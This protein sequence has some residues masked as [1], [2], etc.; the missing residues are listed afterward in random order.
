[1]DDTVWIAKSHSPLIMPMAPV[2]S[3]NKCIVIVRNP[4]DSMVSFLHMAS[5]YNHSQKL[6]FDFETSYP[7]DWDWYV[8]YSCGAITKYYKQLMHDSKHRKVPMIFIRFEDLVRD[9]EP[10]LYKIMRFLLGQYDLTDTNAER[11]IKEVLEM[12]HKAT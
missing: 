12:G 1:M 3:A 6:P 4:L 8:R 10:E 11:R 5:L 7:S 2:F 9:P